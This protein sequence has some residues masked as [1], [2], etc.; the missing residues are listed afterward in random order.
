MKKLIQL[1]FVVVMLF[2]V[3]GANAARP[4]IAVLDFRTDKNSITFGYGF[5]IVQR[6]EDDTSFLSSDLITYLVKTNKFDVVERSRMADILKEQEFSESG[7]ISPET[8]VKMGKLIGADYFVMGK[9]EQLHA[10]KENKP[11]PYTNKFKN[12][13][14]GKM[15]VNVRIVDS[16]GGRVVTA[17]KFTVDL[18]DHN[19]Q[20]KVTPD[21]FVE[22]L[23]E[24]TVKE[25]VNGIVSGVFPIKI[26][27]MTGDQV[28]LNRGAGANFEVGSVLGV[29]KQGE[30]LVDPDTGEQLGSA[31]EE[32]GTIEITEIQNKFT[33]AKI[34]TGDKMVKKDA[35]V[36]LKKDQPDRRPARE[37]TP[38][39]S[40]KPVNW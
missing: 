39:S 33:K 7:Y 11:V 8:A 1:S 14:E 28:Y 16:R 37:E 20:D 29:Y 21:D 4:T 26:I 13:Y 25:I 2:V 35:I 6:I 36:R 23:K 5:V 24:K 22:A 19:V 3:A 12:E 30:G 10:T 34:L 31:E 38:G 18:K 40:D 32:V 9:I 17:E 15:T 27:K